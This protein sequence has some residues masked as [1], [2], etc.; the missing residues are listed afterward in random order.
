MLDLGSGGGID[1]LLSAPRVGPS[2]TV[3]GLDMTDEMLALARRNAAR[4]HAPNVHFLKGLI[5]ACR[6]PPRASTSSSRTAW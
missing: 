5:E 1:V 3:Y 6:F 4:R 2:G